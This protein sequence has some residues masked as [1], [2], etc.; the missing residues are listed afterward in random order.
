MKKPTKNTLEQITDANNRIKE[1]EKQIESLKKAVDGLLK[2]ANENCRKLWKVCE[3]K[4]E[5][6]LTYRELH[7]GA[8]FEKI[9]L[10]KVKQDLEKLK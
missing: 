4:K 6:S 10:E 2:E 8:L 3:D 1:L 9:V 7:T 5:G